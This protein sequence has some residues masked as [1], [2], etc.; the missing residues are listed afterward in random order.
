[1]AVFFT[2][3]SSKDSIVFCVNYFPSKLTFSGLFKALIT[4]WPL[5][6]DSGKSVIAIAIA[7][8]CIQGMWISGY[9]VFAHCT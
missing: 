3:K 5:V 7:Q 2:K 8:L 9:T 6:T 4:I 1:M